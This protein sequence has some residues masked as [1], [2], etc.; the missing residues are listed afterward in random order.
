MHLRSHTGAICPTFGVC[1]PRLSHFLAAPWNI[2]YP[3]FYGSN[4][5]YPTCPTSRGRKVQGMGRKTPRQPMPL[6]NFLDEKSGAS[7]T[8]C[9][10][11]L[12]FVGITCPTLI[13]TSRTA[14]PRAPPVA[15][16]ATGGETKN[17]VPRCWWGGRTLAPKPAAPGLRNFALNPN[18]ISGRG[19]KGGPRQP[20]NIPSQKGNTH[21]ET[22]TISCPRPLSDQRP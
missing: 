1:V 17:P 19:P 2:F 21:A 3:Y 7:G 6:Y 13:L 22:K 11:A 18:P 16:Q 15:N 12:F 4:T 10:S 8:D 14:P 5:L 20:K 9:L